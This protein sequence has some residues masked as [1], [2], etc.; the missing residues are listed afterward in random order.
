[1]FESDSTAEETKLFL[2]QARASIDMALD[3]DANVEEIIPHKNA[4]IIRNAATANNEV[5][6]K[7]LTA[8]ANYFNKNKKEN[9]KEESVHLASISTHVI[10]SLDI[11]SINK[12]ISVINN[13]EN[14]STPFSDVIANEGEKF[15]IITLFAKKSGLNEDFIKKIANY[16]WNG[17]GKF[18]LLFALF[19]RNASMPSKSDIQ[20]IVDGKKITVEVKGN[21]GKLSSIDGSG[22]IEDTKGFASE[23]RK[24]A[25]EFQDELFKKIEPTGIKKDKDETVGNKIIEDAKNNFPVKDD[26]TSI[27]LSPRGR[28]LPINSFMKK[29]KDLFFYTVLKIEGE[30]A[31]LVEIKN[32]YNSIENGIENDL[33][34]FLL[35]TLDF[36]F[37]RIINGSFG[38]KSYE[39]IIENYITYDAKQELEVDID[40]LVQTLGI[41]MLRK[42]K[43]DDN[44]RYFLVCDDAGNAV[45]FDLEEK[46]DE[47]KIRKFIHFSIPGIAPGSSS[48]GSAFKVSLKK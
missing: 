20:V 22:A 29:L 30:T 25:I 43:N 23:V 3:A 40:G 11:D 46:F 48:R 39:N 27:V 45:I 28:C 18:E 8:L 32:H 7:L 19:V 36:I 31:N 9:K 6:K 10:E 4:K 14:L 47:E 41:E 35:N 2:Q 33:K 26:S 16:T 42:Y 17:H 21:E 1:M 34:N 44:F 38:S 37:K 15:N 12:F 5:N 24:M 13:D